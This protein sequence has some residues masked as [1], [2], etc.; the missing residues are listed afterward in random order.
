MRKSEENPAQYP[1]TRSVAIF[2]DLSADCISSSLLQFI[3]SLQN[4][5]HVGFV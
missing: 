4:D 2:F 5:N 3:A 1:K